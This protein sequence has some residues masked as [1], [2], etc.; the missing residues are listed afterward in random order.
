[1]GWS[2]APQPFASMN[3]STLLCS[4][5]RFPL[6]PLAVITPALRPLLGGEMSLEAIDCP[7]RCAE[8]LYDVDGLGGE[9]ERIAV[10]SND[11]VRGVL[12]MA[13]H[14][15]LQPVGTKRGHPLYLF[16]FSGAS[17]QAIAGERHKGG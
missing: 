4:R 3:R 2:E 1:M 5:P 15:A 9:K 14:D 13:E 17:V 16:W 11:F 7:P 8:T 6:R 10:V 12:T